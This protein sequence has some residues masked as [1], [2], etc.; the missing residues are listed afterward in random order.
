MGTP[1]FRIHW[2]PPEAIAM[3]AQMLFEARRRRARGRPS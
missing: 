2:S 1:L 3:L